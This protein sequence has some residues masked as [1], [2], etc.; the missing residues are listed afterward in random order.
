MEKNKT[1]PHCVRN[2]SIEKGEFYGG[3]SEKYNIQKNHSKMK[4]LQQCGKFCNSDKKVVWRNKIAYTIVNIAKESYVI[5][6]KIFNMNLCCG[7]NF[8]LSG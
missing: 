7:K 5:E 6:M 2:D 8:Y 4:K 3:I 1:I